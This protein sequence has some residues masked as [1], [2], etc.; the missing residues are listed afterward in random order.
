MW[1]R[2]RGHEWRAAALALLVVVV[3]ESGA[4]ALG[5]GS[6]SGSGA[7]AGP[8]HIP[9]PAHSTLLRT[10]NLLTEQSQ[11]WYYSVA[12][13]SEDQILSYYQAQAKRLGWRCFDSLASTQIQQGGQPVSGTGMYITAV[14]GKVKI[15]LNS[16]SLEYGSGIAG[17]RLDD[18]AVALKVVLEPAGKATCA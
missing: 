2:L 17:D 18:G 3:V 11:A 12:N 1:K 15:Q 10:E 8:P 16:G 4:L 5:V 7:L 6:P 13:F 9:L 14:T